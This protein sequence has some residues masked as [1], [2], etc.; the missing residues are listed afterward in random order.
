MRRVCSDMIFPSRS[1]YSLTGVQ[2]LFT[3]IAPRQ[4]LARSFQGCQCTDG[5]AVVGQ[6]IRGLY[7][8]DAGKWNPARTKDE[9]RNV[10]GRQSKRR[11]SELL[12]LDNFVNPFLRKDIDRRVSS[13]FHIR[14]RRVVGHLV[15][16]QY[17]FMS[18]SS[19]WRQREVLLRRARSPGL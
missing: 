8:G 6:V 3:S 9:L 5:V 7:V 1:V 12:M 13:S 11:R 14:P 4:Q 10:D 19:S 15:Q 17:D 18:F 2:C 16:A